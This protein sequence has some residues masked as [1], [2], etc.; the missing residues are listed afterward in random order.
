MTALVGLVASACGAGQPAKQG[1][2]LF[3]SSLIAKARTNIAQYEWAR[4]FAQPITE[5]ARPWLDKSD[6]QLWDLMFGAGIKRSWMVWSNGHCPSCKNS[7]PMYTWQMDALNHPW[8]TRCPHCKELFPKNDFAAFQRSGL[9]EHG[10]FDPARANRTLLFNTEHPEA[11]DPMHSFGVDDGEGYVDGANRWRFIGA[12]LIYGQWKQAIV[13]GIRSLAAAYVVTGDAKYAHKAGV[14]LD[15]VADLNPT[16]DFGRQ[17]VMYEGPPRDGYVSTW[18]D[19]CFEVRDLAL[20]YDQ[21]FEALRQDRELVRFLA[22]K[23]QRYKLQNAKSTFTDVQR[24]IEERILRDTVEHRQKI[25]SNYPQTD[26][27]IILCNT[28]LNWPANR[29]EIMIAIDAIL[30]QSTAFPAQWDP[31]LGIHVT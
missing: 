4:T 7:V 20:A 19:A 11:T 14:L 6:D 22:D 17:G 29:K 5:A 18:H 15:R 21:T 28:V 23:A 16:F 9:D 3:P 26:I 10:V 25:E 13:A 2:A 12:Y 30:E 1:S 24:N 8:K 27:S 31:K